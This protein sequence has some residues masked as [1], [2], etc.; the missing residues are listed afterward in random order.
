VESNAVPIK[1]TLKGLP[2]ISG[3]N[4]YLTSTRFRTNSGASG[5]GSGTKVAVPPV[6]ITGEEQDEEEHVAQLLN[7]GVPLVPTFEI[8]TDGLHT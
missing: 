8:N 3:G 5:S 7:A 4:E 2:G 6:V 1:T